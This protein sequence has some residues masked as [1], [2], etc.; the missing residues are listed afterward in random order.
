MFERY[1]NEK[2][3]GMSGIVSLELYCCAGSTIRTVPNNSD[4]DDDSKMNGMAT[5]V[6][7]PV[8]V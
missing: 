5:D 1:G 2:R 4:G 3:R 7:I 6:S 8:F